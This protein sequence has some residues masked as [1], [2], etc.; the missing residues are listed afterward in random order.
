MDSRGIHTRFYLCA[1]SSVAT[2]NTPLQS[3]DCELP[4]EQKDPR[5]PLPTVSRDSSEILYAYC[6]LEFHPSIRYTPLCIPWLLTIVVALH[7]PGWDSFR[8]GS[9]AGTE[10][11]AQA[12]LFPVN[13]LLLHVQI[14]IR[15]GLMSGLG[16]TSLHIG[17]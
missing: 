13:S 2:H 9:G 8:P 3:Q 5:F 10:H 12:I 11:N 15:L 1:G 6:F 17:C 14:R 4:R 7:L 16:E